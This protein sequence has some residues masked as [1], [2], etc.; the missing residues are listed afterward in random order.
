V[1]LSA[2]EKKIVGKKGKKHHNDHGSNSRASATALRTGSA[3]GQKG[4][5]LYI[6][7]TDL[8]YVN[9]SF[10]KTHGAPQG[11]ILTHNPAA[12]MTDETWDE[13]VEAFAIALRN[14]DPVVKA[15]PTWW[16][17]WHVDGFTSKVN[18]LRGQKI[19]Q[20]YRIQTL[21]QQSHTST[22]CQAFDDLPGTTSK[23]RQRKMSVSQNYAH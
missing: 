14:I 13:V 8:K 16:I 4:P 3:A 7:S 17:E 19:M 5:S 22:I 6:L 9:D 15:N 12:Y 2:S 11:S 23:R 1:Q 21:Q 10:L 18:T 20:K